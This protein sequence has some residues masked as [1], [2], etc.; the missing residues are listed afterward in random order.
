MTHVA[1]RLTAKNRDQ[2]R[3]PTLG[4]RVWATF[5][6]LWYQWPTSLLNARVEWARSACGGRLCLDAMA[7]AVLVRERNATQSRR[8]YSVWGQAGGTLYLPPVWDLYPLYPPSQRCGLCQNF[9]QTTL[10][11]RSYKILTSLYPPPTYENVPTRL[12]Q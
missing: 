9:K 5:T 11:T 10:T 1:G 2:L 12:A 7:A 6:F 8:N 3:N 4:N